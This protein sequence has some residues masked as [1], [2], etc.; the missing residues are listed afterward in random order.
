LAKPKFAWEISA[1]QKLSD[2]TDDIVKDEVPLH[3]SYGI[4]KRVSIFT[5][6]NEIIPFILAIA[7]IA[8]Y[9]SVLVVGVWALI[10]MLGYIGIALSFIAVLAFIYIVILR[11]ARKRIKFIRRLKRRCKSL[12][13]TI[14]KKRSFGKGLKFNK[15]GIDFIVDTGKKCFC[16]RYF[17]TKKFLTHVIFADEKTIHLKTNVTRSHFKYVLGLNKPK[18]KYIDYSFDEKIRIDGR[19]VQKILLLNPVPHDCFKKDY[20]GAVIPI[21]T[22]EHMFDYILY[23]GSSFLNALDR[24]AQEI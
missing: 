8:L 1:K 6:I 19:K 20:D 13:F 14:E 24:E 5:Y 7:M 4:K 22:G 16:V 18:M 10:S 23:S 15:E 17:T 3:R 2:P 11:V 21:G 12:G 9:G